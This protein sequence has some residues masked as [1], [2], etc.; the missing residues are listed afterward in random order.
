MICGAALSQKVAA[1]EQNLVG[2][3][4]NVETVAKDVHTVEASQNSQNNLENYPHATTES[5]TPAISPDLHEQE[6]STN[7]SSANQDS[8]RMVRTFAREASSISDEDND[9]NDSS[10]ILILNLSLLPILI[11]IVKKVIH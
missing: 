11:K 5:N 1:D 3:T 4:L 8:N 7:N 6:V 10:D 9:K 2:N